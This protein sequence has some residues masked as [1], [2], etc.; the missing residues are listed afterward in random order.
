M[1]IIAREQPNI[2][3]GQLLCVLAHLFTF[4]VEFHSQTSTFLPF[5][6][7]LFDGMKEITPTIMNEL[8]SFRFTGRFLNEPFDLFLSWLRM[9][10]RASWMEESALAIFGT[11]FA[12]S[13]PFGVVIKANLWSGARL[14]NHFKQMRQ[15]YTN[16]A[17]KFILYQNVLPE[18]VENG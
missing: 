12:Q 16:L 10:S 5:K 1:P 2:E 11:Q 9:T 7:N 14:R 13:K 3:N 18:S 8:I 15:S 4:A 17:K 6:Q